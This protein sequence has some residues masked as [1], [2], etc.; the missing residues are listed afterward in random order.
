MSKAAASILDNP[1]KIRLIDKSNMLAFCMN[2]A[3]HYREA[4][5]IAEQL[6]V[7]Y[8]I[9]KHL[10]VSYNHVDNVVV[11]GMGGSAIG[12]ELLKDWAS[13]KVQVP[14]D[15]CRAYE[16]PAYAH[17]HTLVVLVSYSGETEETLSAFLDAVKRGCMVF[18]VSSG[19]SLL[20]FA[21]KLDL[22]HIR[23]PSGFPPR[24]AL[25]YLF[26]P[27]L[28][29]LENTRLV[30]GVHEELAEALP[31]L[32]RICR[33]NAADVPVKDNF[34]KKLALGIAGTVPVVYG[35]GF[36]RGVAQRFKQQFNEN[37]KVP[38]KWEFLPE[39]N[40]NEIVGWEKADKLAKCFSAIFLRDRDEPSE[41][42]SRIEITQELMPAASKHFEVW[43]QGRSVLARMLSAVCIG[44]FTSVYLAVLRN[45][46]P[47]PV[48]NI[49]LLKEKMRQSGTKEK[50][51][52][53][54]ERLAASR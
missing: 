13:S 11:A 22:P 46:D 26:V 5:K 2:A 49:T 10:S 28:M 20:R 32:E 23:V 39:L 16:L 19:G 24:A 40:H 42:R 47:T 30:A 18:C 8:K 6:S 25:P 43:A 9:A 52:C 51:I 1:E 33:E 37:S 27:L 4:A 35:F 44:D 14:I 36:Y 45:V 48:A 31:L 3:G 50:I 54:L 38:S 34:A 15:V 17:E 21:E 53:A 12:G 7:S 29:L 41:V